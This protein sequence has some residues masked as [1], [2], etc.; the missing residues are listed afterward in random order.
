MSRFVK[1]QLFSMVD[2]L[3]KANKTLEKN[4]LKKKIDQEE[5]TKLLSDCQESALSM[6]NLL[7]ELY[8]EGHEI[9]GELEAYC[10]TLY[11]MALSLLNPLAR[12]E[13]LSQLNR[14]IKR[15]RKIGRAHV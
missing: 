14:H 10:E 3:D 9:V 13:L 7:E 1:K 12:R 8:G 4:L 11:Q 2:L 5:L 6:G 15:L